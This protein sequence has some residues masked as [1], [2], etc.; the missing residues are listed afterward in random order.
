MDL[1]LEYRIDT[2]L[3]KLILI[4][5]SPLGDNMLDAVLADIAAGEEGQDARYWVE[6]TAG[7]GEAHT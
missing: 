5:S 3:E 2:D 1:A 4:D 6:R 7:R